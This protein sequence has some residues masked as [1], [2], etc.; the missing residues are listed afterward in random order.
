MIK[1]ENYFSFYFGNVTIRPLV[2]CTLNK[3]LIRNNK[4]LCALEVSNIEYIPVGL[5]SEFESYEPL[6]KSLFCF[7]IFDFCLI[8]IFILKIHVLVMF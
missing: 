2:D 6:T 3:G 7:I 8:L 5:K 4:K 1:N